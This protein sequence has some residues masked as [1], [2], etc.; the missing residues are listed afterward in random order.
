MKN[1]FSENLLYLLYKDGFEYI[2]LKVEYELGRL[3][4]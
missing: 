2:A 3:L 1:Y 4:N